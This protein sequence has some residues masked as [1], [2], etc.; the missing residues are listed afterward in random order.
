MSGRTRR[1]GPTGWVASFSL[2]RDNR[3][4]MTDDRAPSSSAELLSTPVQF[5]KG[6]GPDRAA[7]LNRLGLKTA[8]DL[9]FF[10][11]RDYQDMT[12]VRSLDQLVDGETVS[13]AGTIEEIDVRNGGPGKSVLGALIRQGQGYLRAVWFNQPHVQRQLANGQHVLLSGQVRYRG[14]RWEMVH[15][16]VQTIDRGNDL[17]R[18]DILPVYP[19]TE[20][21]KQ[22]QIRRI[23]QYVV[24]TCAGEV[25]EVLPDELLDQHRLWPIRAALPQ[26]HFP[27]DRVSLEQARRRFVF[28]ELLVLQLALAL[29]RDLRQRTGQA[30]AMPASPPIDARIRRLFPFTLTDDQRRPLV[31]WWATWSEKC[32]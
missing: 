31:K 4:I 15:P 8:C 16:R 19:L 25:E 12:H 14:L 6:V 29:R 17:P 10:F 13:M 26:I 18:G 7:R 3:G 23:V 30:L 28:Q 9:L 27:S 1:V 11:P 21:L 5:L 32:P 24:Q 2:A 22:S 20:G